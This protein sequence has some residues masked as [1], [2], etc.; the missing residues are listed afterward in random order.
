MKSTLENGEKTYAV[1]LKKRSED[2]E[3][4][5]TRSKGVAA[6]TSDKVNR[7]S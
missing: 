1:G 4:C 6:L 5:I 7:R 2:F 3:N